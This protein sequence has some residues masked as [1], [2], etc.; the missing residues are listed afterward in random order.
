VAFLGKYQVRSKRKINSKT[1]EQFQNINY[2]ECDKFF[3]YDN[4]LRQKI[5]NFQYAYCTIKR[6]SR[7][8]TRNDTM[9]KFFKVMT[10]PTLTYG[11]EYW[12]T[13]KTNRRAVEAAEMKFLHYVVCTCKDQIRND[14]IRQKLKIST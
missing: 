10:V 2:L 14:N 6:T 9:L 12:A 13:N 8:K 5:N 3:S 7:N 4:D 11:L 1:T